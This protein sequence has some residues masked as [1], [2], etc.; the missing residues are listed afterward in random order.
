MADGSALIETV[1]DWTLRVLAVVLIVIS[2]T[3]LGLAIAIR[4]NRRG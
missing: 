3:S 1:L 2:L 4:R